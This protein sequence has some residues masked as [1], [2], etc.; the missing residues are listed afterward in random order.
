MVSVV[1]QRSNSVCSSSSWVNCT[2]TCGVRSSSGFD[3]RADLVLA[4]HDRHQQL[5][6]DFWITAKRMIPNCHSDNRATLKDKTMRC[7]AAVARWIASNRLKL[8]PKTEL[9]KLSLCGVVQRADYIL[10]TTCVSVAGWSRKHVNIRFEPRCLL[11]PG[12][13]SNGS[14][15]PP[16]QIVLLPATS[17][18][19]C[20]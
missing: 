14:Y 18:Q 20:S 2:S 7:T 6:I 5:Y 3:L 10:S 1:L 15:Q 17:Y 8:N 12:S 19:V 11:W 16:R 13:V 9:R 4:L